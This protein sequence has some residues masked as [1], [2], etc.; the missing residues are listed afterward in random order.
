LPPHCYDAK[1][2]LRHLDLSDLDSVKAFAN[3]II[4]GRVPVD[5]LINNA[6]IMMPPRSFTKQGFELQFGT[7]HLAHFAL[8]G[9]LLETLA[10]RPDARVVTVRST[11]HK[12]GFIHFDDLAGERKYG[13]WE[14]YCQ[15]KFANTVFGLELDRRL[16]ASEKPVKSILAHP[17]YSATNLQCWLFWCPPDPSAR[18]PWD[19]SPEKSKPGA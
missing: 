12:K 4:A 16:R 9:L 19:C 7:N 15:S 14:F 13:R 18:G 3:G 11:A 5:V 1:L 10:V 17:G 8:T 2:E 6:G